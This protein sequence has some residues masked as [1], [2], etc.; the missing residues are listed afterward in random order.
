[1]NLPGETVNQKILIHLNSSFWLRDRHRR[2]LVTPGEE[3]TETLH[4]NNGFEGLAFGPG[5][6]VFTGVCPNR[7]LSK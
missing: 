6:I 1:M 3:A 5:K 4:G 7:Y 2:E